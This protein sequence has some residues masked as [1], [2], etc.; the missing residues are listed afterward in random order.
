MPAGPANAAGV[1]S[2]LMVHSAGPAAEAGRG[3]VVE[4]LAAGPAPP[5]TSRRAAWGAIDQGLYGLTNFALSVMVAASVSA[6]EFGAFSVVLIAYTL[7]IGAMEGLSSE[8]FTV[9]YG[10]ADAESARQAL[11]SAAGFVLVAG[12]VVGALALAVRAASA[13]PVADALPAF[14]LVVP[15]LYLQDLWR[16]AFFAM[17]RPKAAVF[18]DAVWAVVQIAAL[19]LVRASGHT[20]V[21]WFVLAWGAGAAAGAAVG[22]VQSRAVPR[23]GRTSWWLRTHWGLGGRFAGEFVALFGAS[24]VVLGVLGATAG[25]AQLGRIRAGQVLFSPLQ[26]LLNAVRLSVTSLAVQVRARDPRRLRRFTLRLGLLIAVLA[27]ASGVVALALPDHLGRAVLG[28][29]WAGA[30]AV[31]LPLSILNIVV[32]LSLAALTALRAAAAAKQ[33]LRAR[34]MTSGLVVV[35][36]TTGVV[37]GGAVGAAWGITAGSAIG[38]LI[39]CWQAQVVMNDFS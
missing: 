34:L 35:F 25:L 30:K 33:S 22:V 4:E 23:L 24:Q 28:D 32:A 39:I 16:F 26:G 6:T 1:V 8:A 17:G 21:P 18:N 3:H 38:L 11:R 27:L 12:L 36:G 19:V 20:S 13:D 7:S 37:V 9:A 14:A 10:D 15:A 2:R 29:S 31:L 5:H